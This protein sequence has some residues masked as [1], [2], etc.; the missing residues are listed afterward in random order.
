[1][2]S[3]AKVAMN[4]LRTYALKCPHCGSPLKVRENMDHFACAFCGAS[5]RVEREGGVIALTTVMDE[6]KAVK[7]G[8]D[9]AAAELAL[10]RLKQELKAVTKSLDEAESKIPLDE[11]HYEFRINQIRNADHSHWDARF[12]PHMWGNPALAPKVEKI[13]NFWPLFFLLLPIIWGVQW[14]FSVSAAVMS[15][16]GGAIF[17]ATI[18][19]TE[20]AEKARDQRRVD[21]IEGWRREELD[22]LEATAREAVELRAEYLPLAEE[23]RKQKSFIEKKISEARSV[24]DS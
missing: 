4:S 2:A 12:N 13:P 17:V 22:Y 24:V 7:H 10:V 15:L 21:L 16:T 18:V 20:L 6:I 9:R 1:M 19:F 11:E 3:L 14:A 23:V 5:V 8:T